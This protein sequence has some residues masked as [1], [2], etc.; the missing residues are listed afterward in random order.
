MKTELKAHQNADLVLYSG[1]TQE[2]N[3][4]VGP[5][6][7]RFFQQQ[8]APSS[9]SREGNLHMQRGGV[10]NNHRI[11]VMRQGSGEICLYGISSQLIFRQGAAMRP[12]EQDILLPQSN[13]V[14]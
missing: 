3:L 6:C 13:Q 11:R 2:L 12:V 8:M 7:N 14:A 5:V 9:G 10:G 4:R 1:L